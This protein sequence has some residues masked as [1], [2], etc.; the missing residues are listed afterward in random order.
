MELPVPASGI[1]LND[2]GLCNYI[3]Y[4]TNIQ[5]MGITMNLT[6]LG[7]CYRECTTFL[8][9]TI[10]LINKQEVHGPHR[11]PEKTVQIKKPYY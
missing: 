7:T 5:A 9:I 8:S 6:M 10:V 4:G 11:S 3:I 1:T 2:F